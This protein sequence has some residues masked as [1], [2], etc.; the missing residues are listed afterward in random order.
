MTI[1][2]K[3]WEE[4]KEITKEEFYMYKVEGYEDLW[5]GNMDYAYE[6]QVWK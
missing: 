5:E 4:S 2:G 3:Y 1:A 6:R